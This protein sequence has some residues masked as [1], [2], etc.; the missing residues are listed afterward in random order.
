MYHASPKRFEEFRGI[1]CVTP[2]RDAALG[3]LRGCEGYLYRVVLSDLAI[4]DEDT[5]MEAAAALG[6]AEYTYAWEALE[7]VAGAIGLLQEWG[8]D[9][10]EYGDM[11]P[12]NGYEHDTVM[13]FAAADA[14]IAEMEEISECM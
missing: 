1:V 11:G 3:Y 7:G 6:N 14:V 5:V 9:A 8:F 13:V 4:A 12:D 10:A 2:D